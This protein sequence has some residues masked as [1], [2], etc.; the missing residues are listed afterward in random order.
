MHPNEDVED[1][2]MADVTSSVMINEGDDC[3]DFDREKNESP[4]AFATG[5]LGIERT[6]EK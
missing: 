5:L 4:P 2:A 1:E 3:D 6:K